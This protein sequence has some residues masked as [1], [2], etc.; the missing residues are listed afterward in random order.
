VNLDFNDFLARSIVFVGFSPYHSS[1]R[2]KTE[3][4]L[5]AIGADRSGFRSYG[6]IHPTTMSPPADVSTLESQ[7][8]KPSEKAILAVSRLSGDLLVLGAGGKMGPTL[9]RMAR[10]AADAAGASCR[11]IAVSR[12]RNEQVRFQL[13]KEG[14]ETIGGDLLDAA[15]LRSLP[16][17]QNVMFMAGFKFGASGSPGE[18]WATNAYLPGAVMSRLSHSRMVAFSTGNVYGMIDAAH[19]GSAEGDELRP[20][21]EYAMS[22]LGRE[23]VISYFSERQQT[24]TVILRLNYAVE[25]RYGVLVDLASK[26]YRN[27]PISLEM[28]YFNCIWQADANAMALA[29]FDLAETPARALNLTGPDLLSTRAVCEEFGRLLNRQ[30]E[31][32]GEESPN[33]LLS[34]ATDTL[35]LLGPVGTP[36]ETML[37]WTAD[38]VRR[39]GENWRRPTHFEVRDGKF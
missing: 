10:R 7:L 28:S 6:V 37:T 35:K 2:S 30:V 31:F 23:R 20:V 9:A 38:W 16:D 19:R 26:V 22:A 13:E 18:T 21:G 32:V 14:V 36:L 24:P 3:F 1:L 11:V 39:G 17:C 33:A 5:K 8:S 4:T 12:F 27:E 29:S 25:L 34:D 15:F